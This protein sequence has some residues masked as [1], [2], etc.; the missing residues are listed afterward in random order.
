MGG[1]EYGTELP[2]NPL[3]RPTTSRNTD[4]WF[5]GQITIAHRIRLFRQ[6]T[7]KSHD[8]FPVFLLGSAGSVNTNP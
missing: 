3:T 8:L 1:A 6:H 5:Q 7:V 2:K 4:R